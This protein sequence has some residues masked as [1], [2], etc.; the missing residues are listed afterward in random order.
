MTSRRERTYWMYNA[1]LLLRL[2]VVVLLLLIAPFAYEVAA[3]AISHLTTDGPQSLSEG[4]RLYQEKTY[5]EAALYY[6]R[7]VLLQSNNA[8]K[9]SVDEAFQGFLGCYTVQD[10]TVD[11]FLFIAMEVMER[12]QKDMALQYIDQALAIEP[13]NKQA[14]ALRVR[15]ESGGAAGASSDVKK[16]KRDNK[17]QPQW[18]TEAARDP[19]AMTDKSPEDLYEYGSTLFS[20]KNYEHCADIFEL[21]CKR[22]GNTLG[23]SCSNAVY[24]RMMIMDYGFNGT[25][26]EKDMI[27]LQTLAETEKSKWRQG[28]LENFQWKRAMST[29]PHMMLGYPLPP[30]LK[31]YVAESVAYMDEMMARVS[32]EGG[33]QSLTPLPDDMPFDPISE[34][35]K[36]VM[37]ANQLDFKIKVGFVGSGFNSKAV[38]YLSQDIFRFYDRDKI[39]MHIFSLGPAD[40]ENFIDIGM[41]GVDW[42]ERVREHVDFFHDNEEIK[43]D[44]IGLARYIH[45]QGIHILIEWDGYARQGERAQGLMALRPSPLQIL[46]QEFL[47]QDALYGGV[48]IITRSDGDDMSS[49]VTTSGNIVLG[50]EELNAYDGSRQYEDIAIELGNNRTKFKAVRRQLIDTAL[51]SNPMHPYWDAPR[52]AKNLES[53]LIAAWERFLAGKD[54]DVIEVVESTEA[55]RGTY[56]QILEDN[57]SNRASDHVEL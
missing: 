55:S 25:G 24:C 20:R 5:D 48:P 8:D 21:S 56:D 49:R 35:E 9:Y 41:R 47:A 53:G 28:D 22:S 32:L 39:E 44:H 33:A 52:Y 30:M 3:D 34:R 18:G 26:F 31:R 46:H 15:F 1:S 16:K 6:W 13:D 10:R 14:L 4:K 27:R 7:A 19:S 51:Q 50:L 23:P 45:D 11:G 29:H 38:L 40:N 12:K 42:R 54:P 57:P 2:L 36:Y 17:F 37:E 43:M